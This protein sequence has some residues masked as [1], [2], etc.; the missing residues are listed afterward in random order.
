MFLVFGQRVAID[1][2][3]IYI[4]CAEY[5]QIWPQHVI[6]EVLVSRSMR[7]RTEPETENKGRNPKQRTEPETKN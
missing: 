1:K 7:E 6:H 5:V 2:D 3:I 4:R